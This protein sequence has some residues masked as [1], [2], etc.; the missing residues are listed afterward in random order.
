MRAGKLNGFKGELRSSFLSC[1]KDTEEILTKLFVDSRPYSDIL[2]RLMLVNTTDCLDDLTNPAYIE[3]IKK[4]SL[5]DMVKKGY[6]IDKS[7]KIKFGENEEVKS[8]IVISY[9]NFLPNKKNPYYRDNTIMIDVLCHSDYWDLGNFR[10]RPF[11][12]MGY[13]DGILNGSKLSGLGTLNFEGATEIVYSENL[14]GYCMIY[15]TT[16]GID[17][18]LGEDD[19]DGQPVITS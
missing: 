7:K 1:E 4:T 18:Y 2:K 8:Y 19:D 16:H 12:I 6:I 17:D 11:K 5:A 15:S 9:D 3:K 14:S 13:I 10:L